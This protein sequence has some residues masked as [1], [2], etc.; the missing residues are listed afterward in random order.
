MYEEVA[1][2]AYH[3]HWSA[4]TILNLEHGERRRWV[5]EISAINDRINEG[6]NP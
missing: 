5:E 3:F 4:E 1:F 2:V 6:Y